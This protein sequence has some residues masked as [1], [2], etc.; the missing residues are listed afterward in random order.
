[1]PFVRGL[2]APGSSLDTLGSSRKQ[3]VDNGSSHRGQAGADWLTTAW[4][5]IIPVHTAIHA[6]WLNQIEIY[7]PIVGRGSM[8][9][10]SGGL[11]GGGGPRVIEG[12]GSLASRR[13]LLAVSSQWAMPHGTYRI[14]SR[15]WRNALWRSPRSRSISSLLISLGGLSMLARIPITTS[16][17]PLAFLPGQFLILCPT[18]RI[19]C[20]PKMSLAGQNYLRATMCAGNPRC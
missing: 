14:S 17:I 5:T 13:P 2:T 15:Y 20:G 11:R 1:M 4:P 8:V 10:L 6:S 7:F 16:T 19:C 3:T 18:F 9:G 12:A